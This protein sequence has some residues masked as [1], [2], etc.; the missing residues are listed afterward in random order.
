MEKENNRAV[1]GFFELGVAVETMKE[2]FEDEAEKLSSM[3]MAFAM[4]MQCLEEYRSAMLRELESQAITIKEVE[5]G[6]TYVSRCIELIKQLYI[7]TEAKRLR[8][9]GGFDALQMAVDKIKKTYDE[10]LMDK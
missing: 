9:T 2:T 6:K 10:S 8:A 7:D 1:Q 5:Y 4:S 3:K